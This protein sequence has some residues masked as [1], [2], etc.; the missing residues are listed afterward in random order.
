VGP[1][2]AKRLLFGSAGGIAGTI[3]GTIVVM[4][5]LAAGSRGSETDTAHLAAIV[6]VTVLVLWI[7]HVYSHVLAESLE[8]GRR[9][10]LAEFAAMAR[11]ELAIP[12]AAVAPIAALVLAGFD[13]LGEQTAVRIALGFG[14]A[15]LAVQGF[16]YAALERLGRAGT[17]VSV[18]LNV[19]LGLVIVVLEVSLAH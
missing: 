6:A 12:A 7:A 1:S 14:V 13:L 3:Y 4:A 18:A 8:R 11:R 5:T 10:D 19:F 9:L 2:R 16:R 15:T 17:V